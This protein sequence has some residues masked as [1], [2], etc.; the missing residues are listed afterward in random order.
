LALAAPLAACGNPRQAEFE[1][2]KQLYAA[3]KAECI[4]QNPRSLAMQADCRT[5]AANTFVRPY[6]RYG[7]L[8]TL[9]QA[10]RKILAVKA[11][12]GEITTDEFDL[13]MAQVESSIAREENL[14]NLSERSVS[15]QESV[16][17]AQALGAAASFIRATQPPTPPVV[18]TTCNRIG[19][20]TNC[21][22]R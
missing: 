6:Y 17:A 16:G 21:T 1:K 19:S 11:D 12:R 8:M 18:N 10:Q 3:A 15:A 9:V 22:S 2:G 4:A 13:Q 7:D 14:R 5:Q 20:F